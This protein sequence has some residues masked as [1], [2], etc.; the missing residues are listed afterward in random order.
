MGSG[1]RTRAT[2]GT[3]PGVTTNNNLPAEGM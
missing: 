1:K 2:K 3:T